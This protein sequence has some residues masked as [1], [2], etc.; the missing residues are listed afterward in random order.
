[1]PFI[2]GADLFGR[3]YKIFVGILYIIYF[4][5]I[6]GNMTDEDV[7]QRNDIGF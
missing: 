2:C 4:K 7:P 6:L 5:K 1:M 3:L